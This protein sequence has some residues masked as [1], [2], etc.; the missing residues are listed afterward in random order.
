MCISGAKDASSRFDV[1]AKCRDVLNEANSRQRGVPK[2]SIQIV[3]L[4]RA[5]CRRSLRSAV[6][7][8]RVL[9]EME[10]AIA[11]PEISVSRFREQT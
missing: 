9:K 5:P 1:M 7:A 3:E 4:E 8:W 6:Q 2:E 11:P 10:K